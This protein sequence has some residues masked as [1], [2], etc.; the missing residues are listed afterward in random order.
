MPLRYNENTPATS[1]TQKY[2]RVL[3]I[4]L[5]LNAAMFFI[6]VISGIKASSTS[7][8]ADSLDFLSDAVSYGTSIFVLD[9]ALPMRAKAAMFN[10][11]SMILYGI[12]ILGKALYGFF[13]QV[14]PNH[15][16]MGIVAIL[17]LLVNVFVALL[18]Y[19]YRSGDSNRRSI[20]LC[21]GYDAFGNI[22]V[23]LAAAGVSITHTVYP[24]LLAAVLIASFSIWGALQVRAHAQRDMS[25]TNT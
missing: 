5:L 16:T 19:R 10:A 21:S 8:L 17:G 20:W 4:A 25:Q 3:W 2:R 11:L 6:E 12:F 24:D 7:L 15:Q 22:A 1:I 9:L 14:M 18:L 13:F 23:M